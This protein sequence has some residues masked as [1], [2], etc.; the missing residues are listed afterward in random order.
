MVP[1]LGRCQSLGWPHNGRNRVDV[2]VIP[3]IQEVSMDATEKQ[4]L[5]TSSA[6]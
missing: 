5:L 3:R 6:N 1:A 2:E 4:M